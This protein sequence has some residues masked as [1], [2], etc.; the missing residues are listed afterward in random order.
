MEPNFKSLDTEHSNQG[1]LI[2]SLQTQLESKEKQLKSLEEKHYKLLE[3]FNYNVNLIYERD[4][5][6]DNLNRKIDELLKASREKDIQLVSMQTLYIKIKQL[7]AD[8]SILSSRVDS[9]LGSSNIP[10]NSRKSST[11]VPGDPS[12]F[13]HKNRRGFSVDRK[14]QFSTP[15]SKINSELE[16]RIQAL[17]QEGDVKKEVNITKDN[18]YSKEREISE[19]IKS[20]SPYKKEGRKTLASSRGGID[21][22]LSDVK[23]IKESILRTGSRNSYLDDDDEGKHMPVIRNM[24]SV[25]NPR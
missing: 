20:L 5:E 22:F 23:K 9:L 3:D 15:L 24:F 21:G 18:V 14:S 6:I 1:A 8:K 13:N 19:L 10:R 7:E 17:E 25:D 2:K 12:M 16:K 11:P 4:K